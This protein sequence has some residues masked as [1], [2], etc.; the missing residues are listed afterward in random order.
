MMGVF[1]VFIEMLLPAFSH[2][3]FNRRLRIFTG[4][5]PQKGARGLC[6]DKKHIT[7]GREFHPAPKANKIISQAA[8]LKENEEFP[9]F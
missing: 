6:A 3:D 8:Q 1:Q 9:Q 5:T 7:A 4:S 2:P